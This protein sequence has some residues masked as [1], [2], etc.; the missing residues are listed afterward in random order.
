MLRQRFDI[1]SKGRNQGT[2]CFEGYRHMLIADIF[3]PDCLTTSRIMRG[4]P[5]RPIN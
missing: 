3:A 4:D 5:G 2:M 1:L